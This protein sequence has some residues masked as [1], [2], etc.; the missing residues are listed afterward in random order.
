M[1][2]QDPRKVGILCISKAKKRNPEAKQITSQ[3]ATCV[4]S[5]IAS[6]P[7]SF[8]VTALLREYV[9][10]SKGCVT[11]VAELKSAAAVIVVALVALDLDVIELDI[12]ELDI[13]ELDC[14][15][16][17]SAAT[18]DMAL[19]LLIMELDI[20]VEL[21]LNVAIVVIVVPTAATG[22]TADS[23]AAMLTAG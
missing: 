17:A 14:C 16:A 2:P 15:D 8:S 21:D 13:M 22:E 3:I 12:I 6:R 7:P 18:G 10:M 1:A 9:E 4:A 23:F 20:I 5:G 11:V 19:A